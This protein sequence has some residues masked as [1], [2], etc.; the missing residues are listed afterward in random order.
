MDLL[1]FCALPF[2]KIPVASLPASGMYFSFTNLI[3]ALAFQEESLLAAG[4]DTYGILFWDQISLH[5]PLL[6]NLSR[7]LAMD[8][9]RA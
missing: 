3:F 4:N 5:I 8:F 1:V 7:Q 2:E 9:F 6:E